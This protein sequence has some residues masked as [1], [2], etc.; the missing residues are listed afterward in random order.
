MAGFFLAT[1]LEDRGIK[2]ESAADAEDDKSI[3]LAFSKKRVEDRKIWLAGY[4]SNTHLDQDLED[5]TYSDFI[6]KVPMD[7]CSTFFKKCYL[8]GFL[9]E[10]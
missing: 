2:A 3:E 7:S 6:N 5:I 4:T 10:V 8:S 1:Q 9:W